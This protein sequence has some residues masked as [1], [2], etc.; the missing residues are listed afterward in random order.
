M[1]LDDKA[2]RAALAAA[3]RAAFTQLRADHPDE[4]LYCYS[5]Y[6]T[7]E[8][9]WISPL[10]LGR[11]A[12]RRVAT[13]Y[14]ADNVE[15]QMDELRWSPA[16]S[17]YL[18]MGAE[19]FGESEAILAALPHIHELPHD[20]FVDRV[21]RVHE[22]CIGALQDLDAEGFFGSGSERDAVTLNVFQGD[23]SNRSRLDNARRLNPPAACERIAA[24]L[25]VTREVGT[26]TTRGD[27]VYQVN[28][29]AARGSVI[30]AVASKRALAWRDIEVLVDASLSGGA[31]CVAVVD[32]EILTAV[33]GELHRIPFDGGPVV[34]SGRHTGRIG[35]IAASGDGASVFTAGRDGAII[36]SFGGVARWRVEGHAAGL[37]LSAD[38]RRLYASGEGVRILAA[39]SGD[40]LGRLECEGAAFACVAASSRG[41][42]AAGSN[43]AGPGRVCLWSA[44]GALVAELT[45]P[46]LM[47]ESARTGTYRPTGCAGVAF[48]P[49]GSRLASAH[50]SGELHVWDAVTGEHITTVRGRHESLSG[51]G[52][53]DDARVAL[54]GRDVDESPAVSVFEV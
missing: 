8:Y 18:E 41:A 32:A 25:L 43:T 21:R 48:S 34:R 24:D 20:Q 31:W 16:D 29:V 1:S 17:S 33:D 38:E 14:D 22:C 15:G 5:L 11:E 10:V 54:G 50:T 45:I 3:A 47:P 36:A 53:L 49:D 28:D 42:V 44:D 19:H 30:A 4:Q 51:C 9:R 12:L 2:L 26:F 23:Q 27:R 37:A 52:W 7:P 6:T 35:S 40:E 13:D 46:D 39:D